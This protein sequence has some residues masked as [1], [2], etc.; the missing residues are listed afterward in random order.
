MGPGSCDVTILH[1]EYE[2]LVSGALMSASN[3]VTPDAKG[4]AE[5]RL[6]GE[7]RHR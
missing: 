3:I 4:E 1:L 7:V 2:V 6:R 5:A